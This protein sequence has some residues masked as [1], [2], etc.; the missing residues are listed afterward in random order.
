MS[1]K[2]R[3][4]WRAKVQAATSNPKQEVPGPQTPTAGERPH[5]LR[6][7]ERREYIEQL[8]RKFYV[9]AGGEHLDLSIRNGALTLAMYESQINAMRGIGK[10]W[11]L[12]V[13]VYEARMNRSLQERMMRLKRG[14][15][16]DAR[17]KAEEWLS[18]DEQARAAE[19]QAEPQAAAAEGAAKAEAADAQAGRKPGSQP[20]SETLE[21]KP[22]RAE[23]VSDTKAA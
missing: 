9:D 10:A 23:V 3:K 5:V 1:K 21:Q 4:A 12:D 7:R 16:R 20:V 14:L 13:S 11:G 22:T 17:E 18:E 15:M 6:G 19:P 8:A 2:H